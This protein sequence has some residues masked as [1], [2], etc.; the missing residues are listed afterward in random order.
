LFDIL[1]YDCVLQ[2]KA[3]LGS[4]Y[5]CPDT[6]YKNAS[7]RS[8]HALGADGINAPVALVIHAR[9]ASPFGRR[10]VGV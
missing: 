9:F 3:F 10:G 2:C 8:G 7:S 5:D 1:K 6:F 4:K